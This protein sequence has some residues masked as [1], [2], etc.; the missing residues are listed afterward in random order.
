MNSENPY[1]GLAELEEDP[2]YKAI[3]DRLDAR[4]KKSIIEMVN[5][6]K[7]TNSKAEI[8]IQDLF[9]G[10]DPDN[11][12][13]NLSSEQFA[14]YT[15]GLSRSDK[16]KYT[17]MYNRMKIQTASEERS[18]YKRASNLLRDQLLIDEHIEK[19][20]FGKISGD[21]EITLL[22]A[23]NKLIDH[24]D[25]QGVMDEKSLKD[26]VKEFSS[27]E[28][29]GKV[30]NPT[31]KSVFGGSAKPRVTS[32]VTT[33]PVKTKEL[34]LSPKD[35]IVYKKQFRESYGYIPTTKDEKFKTFL[36]KNR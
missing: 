17:N 8:K 28:I 11:S 3:F 26:F 23:Q 29:K 24:L 12:I 7:E 34:V 33:A 20:K 25:K 18:T 31:P 14:Q 10:N 22:K 21:D 35:L 36:E 2:A 32:N 5:A 16:K 6:P 1:N 30:F 4:S 19:D 27:A 9:F 13:E 15:T